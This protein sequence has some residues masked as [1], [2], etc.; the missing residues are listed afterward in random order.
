MSLESLL[1]DSSRKAVENAAMALEDNPELFGDMLGLCSRPYPLAMRAARVIQLFC[2]KYTDALFS[3]LD[4]LTDEL[5]RTRVD[6]VKRSFLKIMID[7]ID[8]NKIHNS[9]LVFNQCLDWLF[10]DKETIAVRAYS[11]DLLEKFAKNEPDLRNELI[12][13]FENVPLE[14]YPSLEKRRSRCFKSLN[15]K[16]I[17]YK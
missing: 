15:I 3:Y 1:Y 5:L 17:T 16:D 11:I 4:F 2:D 6:G 8:I 14:D 9:G 7:K 10:S 13:V 12:I